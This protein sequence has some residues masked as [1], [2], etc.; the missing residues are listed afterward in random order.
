MTNALEQT[1]YTARTRTT[2][3]RDGSGRSD[4]GALDVRLSTPGSNRPGSNPEQLFAVG[5]SACFIG[6]MQLAAARHN[7]RLPTDTAIEAEVSLGKTDGGARYQLAAK[8]RIALPGLDEALKRTLIETAHDTC[9][10]SRA[11]RG[12]IDVEFELI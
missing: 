2:G 11:I 4:D 8:L 9:P 1:L 3:G 12:N 10:Y 5:Y 7:V 6:A